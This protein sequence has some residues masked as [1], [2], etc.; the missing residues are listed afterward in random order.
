MFSYFKSENGSGL[1]GLLLVIVVIAALAYGGS[2]FWTRNT[3]ENINNT[4]VLDEYQQAQIDVGDINK[5][6][7]E[8]NEM[9]NKVAST[10][11]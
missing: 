10:T 7:E 11:K 9:I 8:N 3:K 5:K 4:N 6:L 1:I 2:F